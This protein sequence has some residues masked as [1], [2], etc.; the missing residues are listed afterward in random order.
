MAFDGPDQQLLHDPR[1]RR[2]VEHLLALG[3]R[4]AGEFLAEVGA[5]H[6]ITE[7]IAAKLDLWRARLTPSM[8]DATGGDRWPPL[9]S[10]LR[11]GKP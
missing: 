3:P 1:W 7:R 9:L 11:G 5:E 4:A 6:G 8:L 10:M 2:G